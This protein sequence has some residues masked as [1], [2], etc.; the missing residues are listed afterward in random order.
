MTS[1][2]ATAESV[3]RHIQIRMAE[4]DKLRRER[5]VKKKETVKAFKARL[6]KKI[7]R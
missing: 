4:A 7:D 2:F 3:E 1:P 6:L 5:A